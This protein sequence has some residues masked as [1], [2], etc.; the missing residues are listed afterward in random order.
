MKF[1]ADE[2]CDRVLLKYCASQ[3]M[4]S[5]IN[6]IFQ[7]M[8]GHSGRSIPHKIWVVRPILHNFTD[9]NV[10]FG[11]RFFRKGKIPRMN[12][13]ILR[14]DHF[15]VAS[16]NL[17]IHFISRCERTATILDDVRVPVVFISCKEECRGR[18]HV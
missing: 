6:R 8:E 7:Y 18:V 10:I 3:G 13:N 2:C 12:Y 14:S 4:M 16:N 11:Q 17:G 9:F 5:F 15:I 1:L